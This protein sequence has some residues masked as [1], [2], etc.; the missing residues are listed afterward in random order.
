[1]NKFVGCVGAVH[2]VHAKLLPN[3]HHADAKAD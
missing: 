3:E 1:M 2:D